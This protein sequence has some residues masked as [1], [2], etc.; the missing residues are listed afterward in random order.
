M[1]AYFRLHSH[2]SPTLTTRFGSVAQFSMARVMR[3]ATLSSLESAGFFSSWFMSPSANR[4]HPN[5]CFSRTR[6]ITSRSVAS[7][8]TDHSVFVFDTH[9]TP[10]IAEPRRASRSSDSERLAKTPSSGRSAEPRSWL[11]WRG[12]P[13]ACPGGCRRAGRAC[14]PPTGRGVGCRRGGRSKPTEADRRA[15]RATSASPRP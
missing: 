6:R 4:N 12:T 15:G 14:P 2:H 7:L 1:S 13:S 10:S 8:R 11:E 3:R 5:G 9:R